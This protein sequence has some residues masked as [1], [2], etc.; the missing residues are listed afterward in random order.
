MGES[1]SCNGGLSTDP[2]AGGLDRPVPGALR[3]YLERAGKPRQLLRIWV[4][5]SRAALPPAGGN[6]AAGGWAPPC[7][8]PRHLEAPV[9]LALR[10]SLG[11]SAAPV[12]APSGKSAGGLG[13]PAPP[14][15]VLTWP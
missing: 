3:L 13:S 5:D 9:T 12:A 8:S 14:R 15:A 6:V 10:T 4:P 11:A 1:P 2:G 7:C